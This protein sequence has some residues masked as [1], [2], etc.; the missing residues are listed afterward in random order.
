MD[1]GWLEWAKSFARFFDRNDAPNCRWS[2]LFKTIDGFKGRPITVQ[3]EGAWEVQLVRGNIIDRKAQ[4]EAYFSS[5]TKGRA[6]EIARHAGAA[7]ALDAWR[8]LIDKGHSLKP[9]HQ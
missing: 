6:R 7:G 2:A 1:D 4:L 3:D 9:M 5:Y 8:I